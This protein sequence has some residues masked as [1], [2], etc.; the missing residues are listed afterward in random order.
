MA[1]ERRR[2]SCQC[3]EN[4]LHH[5]RTIKKAGI[6]PVVCINAFHF[7]SKE[8]HDLVRRVCEAEGARADR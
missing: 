4:L 2:V 3:G 7:D 8:E 6:N 5:I 1:R